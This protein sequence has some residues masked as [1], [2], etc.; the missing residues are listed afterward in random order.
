MAG[1]RGIK[2]KHCGRFTQIKTMK[3]MTKNNDHDTTMVKMMVADLEVM[4]SGGKEMFR[5]AGKDQVEQSPL[6]RRRINPPPSPTSQAPGQPPPVP[7][8]W[9]PPSTPSVLSSP[10]CTPWRR[11]LTTTKPRRRDAPPVAMSTSNT[12]GRSMGTVMAGSISTGLG[13]AGS[14]CTSRPSQ[15]HGLAIPAST[16]KGHTGIICTSRISLS[17]GGAG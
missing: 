6:K 10:A 1:G 7:R 5:F 16:T 11:R 9:P 17:R 14:I 3:T 4:E 2:T 15:Q 12:G 13:A 8:A